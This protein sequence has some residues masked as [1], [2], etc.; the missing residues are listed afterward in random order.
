[1]I[2]LDKHLW[3]RNKFDPQE[4]DNKDD[5]PSFDP[6]IMEHFDPEESDNEE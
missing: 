6:E 4:S 3:N 5:P 1:M 2:L